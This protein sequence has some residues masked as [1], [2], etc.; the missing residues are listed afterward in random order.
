MAKIKSMKSD[1][2]NSKSFVDK[3]NNDTTNEEAENNTILETELSTTEQSTSKA[4]LD[5]KEKTKNYKKETMSI[6]EH[7]PPVRHL[8]KAGIN[9]S[10]NLDDPKIHNAS[11]TITD[12]RKEN[13][14]K[15][16]SCLS[17]M[18]IV[19]WFTWLI[20]DKQSLSRPSSR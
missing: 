2:K 16:K 15:T 13:R 20:D 6:F 14:Y 18:N 3:S 5:L 4:S 12:G 19:N 1:L 9:R 10:D 11:E 8:K 7:F 17:Q